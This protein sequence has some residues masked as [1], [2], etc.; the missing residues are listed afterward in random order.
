MSME[1]DITICSLSHSRESRIQLE[2]NFDLTRMLNPGARFQWLVGNN[3]IP[4]SAESRFEDPEGR[5][6]VYEGA[7]EQF[8]DR[9][10]GWKSYRH[11]AG[12]AKLF[13]HVKT[14]FFAV[15]DPDFYIVKQNWIREVIAH[16]EQRGFTFFGS[17]WHPRYYAKYRYFP[18]VQCTFVNCEKVSPSDI[19]FMPGVMK[20]RGPG[21]ESLSWYR[22]LPVIL[23]RPIVYYPLYYISPFER[24]AIGGSQDIGYTFWRRFSAR[25]RDLSWG[26]LQ[27]VF[28]PWRES[29]FPHNILFFPNALI[30]FFLPDRFSFYPKRRK[31]YSLSGFREMGYPDVRGRRFGWEEYLWQGKP[32]AFHLRGYRSG[33]QKETG[34]AALE[35]DLPL[36]DEILSRIREIARP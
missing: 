7:G 36:L 5:F 32:F 10:P 3:A 18:T 34:G 25:R 26:L 15:L 17:V 16:M 1:Y 9:R 11:G 21:K 6:T 14:R 22:R 19:D 30:E 29:R 2:R 13:P 12:L 28:V 24:H 8:L 33:Y 4:G 35:G 20:E 23:Q 27:P 31:Y